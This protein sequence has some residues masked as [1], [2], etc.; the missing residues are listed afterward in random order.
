MVGESSFN[1]NWTKFQSVI[2]KLK[3]KRDI[4]FHKRDTLQIIPPDEIL[5]E[6]EQDY[7][8]MKE[9]MII[10]DSKSFIDL[11]ERMKEVMQNFKTN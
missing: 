4:R 3:D 8:A 9:N 1:G 10:G 6:W 5:T 7:K 2:N 11:L